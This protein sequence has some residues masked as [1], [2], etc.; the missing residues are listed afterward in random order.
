L[1]SCSIGSKTFIL[2]YRYNINR[3]GKKIKIVAKK[4]VFF[5]N[6]E[7]GP[8]FPVFIIAEI[9]TDHRGELDRAYA[10]VDK[11]KEAGADCAK[12]QWVIADEIVHPELGT[13]DLPGGPTPLYRKFKALEQP[14][15]FYA[16]LMEYTQKQGLYFLCSVF[17]EKSL[18]LYQETVAR[19][20]TGS[21]GT[22]PG[23]GPA[24]MGTAGLKIASPE[25]NHIPLLK[26]AGETRMPVILSTGMSTLGDIE[27]ALRYLENDL[28]L[29]HCVTAYPAPENES[30]LRAVPLLSAVF[31]VPAGLSDHSAGP[32]LIPAAAAALGARVIEKHICLEKGREGLDD[33]FALTPNEFAV[34]CKAVRKA[35]SLKSGETLSR[36]A[37][38]FTEER[39]ETVLG[40]ALK[41]VTPTEA[42]HYLGT[43]RSVRALSD[44]A[45]G[46]RLTTENS[47]LLRSSGRFK[48]GVTP[49]FYE[50][51][52]GKIVTKPVK[53]G[54]GIGWDDLLSEE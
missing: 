25:I 39:V 43:R 31:S 10:L 44:L 54:D 33:T 20:G 53:A 17:G 21:E 28:I 8:S 48:P 38:Q 24:V 9:G 51:I 49:E 41:K 14:A 6:R 47:A 30:N 36:L 7:I 23:T 4:T 5:G 15:E 18:R 34:M 40:A 35:E 19:D 27:N 1:I 16:R 29:L 26:R 50:I 3:G 22:G 32:V 37:E 11:A 45:P 46:T 42:G 52:L 12:F 2:F 13:M